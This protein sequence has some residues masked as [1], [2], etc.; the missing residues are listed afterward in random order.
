LTSEIV[1]IIGVDV[2]NAVCECEGG[3]AMSVGVFTDQH[4][5]WCQPRNGLGNDHAYVSKS[6]YA[7]NVGRHDGAARF[8]TKHGVECVELVVAH[9][10][11]VRDD[12]VKTS[13][14]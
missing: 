6:R 10:G 7:V 8:V 12:E 4:P 11:R 9:V 13:T 14:Q 3:V 1:K 5:R 2:A